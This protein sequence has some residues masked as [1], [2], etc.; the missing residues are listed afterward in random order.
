MLYLISAVLFMIALLV[1]V[2]APRNVGDNFIVMI[3]LI[4]LFFAV[5]QDENFAHNSIIQLFFYIISQ[6]SVY[7]APL[8]LAI[9]GVG[10]QLQSMRIYRT[11][12]SYVQLVVGQL[13]G[14]IL[15]G[16][17]IFQY[18]FTFFVDVQARQMWI[19]IPEF[20]MAYYVLLFLNYLV[21]ILRLTILEDESKK[22]YVIVLGEQVDK[23]GLP[24]LSLQERLNTTLKYVNRQRFLH[25]HMPFIIVSGA[26]TKPD[27]P[28][29]AETMANYLISH[30]IDA[31]HILKEEQ[32]MNTHQ[33]F[34][35]SK[36]II[37]S[38]KRIIETVPA[39]FV[40]SSYHLYRSQL[41]ANMEG[42][43]QISGIGSPS[44]LIDRIFGFF[45]EY[46][47]V[48]FMHRK[49][50]L[51]MSFLMIALGIINYVHFQ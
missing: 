18:Y 10:M 36:A 3:G 47:A 2:I 46:I 5:L 14:I 42:L 13:L 33:N 28:S 9:F 26:A 32:A 23:D 51:A 50:H 7:A 40:T 48:I 30:G 17:A 12:R 39:V 27:L 41:Y 49:L 19:R 44:P 38:Q 16:M 11:E 35:Y 4:V 37:C 31:N 6:V 29:E 21:S 43:Y 22:D 34:K 1:F 8:L 24:T 45:R 20:I 15:S 25:C